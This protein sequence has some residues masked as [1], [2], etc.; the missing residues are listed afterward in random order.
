MTRQGGG[1]RVL[2]GSGWTR[3]LVGGLLEPRRSW[4]A[5]DDVG[6][7]VRERGLGG[8]GNVGREGREADLTDAA[9]SWCCESGGFFQYTLHDAAGTSR[10]SWILAPGHNSDRVMGERY[11]STS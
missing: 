8:E 10:L 9:C 7:L 5:V 6:G 3:W 2:D 11:P 1:C 4:A